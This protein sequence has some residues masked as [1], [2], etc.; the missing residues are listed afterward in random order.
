MRGVSTS[1]HPDA[2][3]ILMIFLLALD[4]FGGERE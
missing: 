3:E 1:H 2:K 4:L